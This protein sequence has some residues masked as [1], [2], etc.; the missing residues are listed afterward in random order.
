MNPAVPGST[1]S[2]LNLPFAY[3]LGAAFLFNLLLTLM[4][5]WYMINSR[6]VSLMRENNKLS[7]CHASA[8]APISETLT[9]PIGVGGGF[10]FEEIRDETK[11]KRNNKYYRRPN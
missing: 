4:I 9:H 10:Y 11:R 2:P 1:F 3:G 7:P 6:C 8:I 5:G